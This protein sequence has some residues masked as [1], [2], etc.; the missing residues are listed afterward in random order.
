MLEPFLWPKGLSTIATCP[1]LLR[2]IFA[3]WRGSWRIHVYARLARADIRV[4]IRSEIV[5]IDIPRTIKAGIV[6]IAADNRTDSMR[7]D[8]YLSRGGW[9]PPIP[10]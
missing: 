9:A 10:A 4:R 3:K 1:F 8:P 5:Q 6:P 7:Q 2:S